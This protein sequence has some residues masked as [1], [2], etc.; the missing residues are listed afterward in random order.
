MFRER[1]GG[2]RSG[3]SFPEYSYSVEAIGEQVAEGLGFP[4]LLLLPGLPIAEEMLDRPEGSR[5]VLGHG[6]RDG[7]GVLHDPGDQAHI[8]GLRRVDGPASEREVEGVGL[9]DGSGQAAGTAPSPE[10]AHGDAGFG[11]GRLRGRQPDIRSQT[12]FHTPT[13]RC[14]V[15]PRDDDAVR[16]FDG[17]EHRLTG[18]G[19]FRCGL[20]LQRANGHEVGS[21]TEGGPGAGEVD[22]RF[23]GGLDRGLEVLD[24]VPGQGV[25]TVGPSQ[26]YR[27]QSPVLL[28]SNHAGR[29]RSFPKAFAVPSLMTVKMDEAAQARTAARQAIAEISPDR[30]RSVIDSHLARASMIPG[31]LALL[32]ARVVGG[33]ADETAVTNRAVGVQ[34]IYEGLRLTRSLVQGE[35][36]A[37]AEGNIED[38][39][40]ILAADVLVA[41]GFQLLAHTE[42]ADKAVETVR[43]FG[44]E[45]TDIRERRGSSARSL[46]ANV[47]E[48]AVIAGSTATGHEAPLS[49]RQYVIGLARSNGDPPLPG[50]ADGLPESIEEV[51]RRVGSQATADER[52]RTHSATDT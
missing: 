13:P 43:E 28:A 41:R 9:P 47:F 45:Q 4:F 11:E 38:D 35:P 22:D 30:L 29:S 3:R 40:D 27:P 36:W 14:A 46:E 1:V 26:R 42:A 51:M 52:V 8:P 20:L 25:S 7:S 37:R 24:S 18:P 23:V 48:L 49:L 2:V 32:S 17:A 50:S 33:E 10:D 39:L 44:H 5:I 34:L 15:D 21:G 12:E 31:V 6:F 16:R 19:K